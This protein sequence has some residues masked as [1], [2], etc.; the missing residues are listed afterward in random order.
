VSFADRGI[1]VCSNTQ[2]GVNFRFGSY[3]KVNV[4]L[5]SLSGKSVGEFTTSNGIVTLSKKDCQPGT[6]VVKWHSENIEG[7]QKVLLQGR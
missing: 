1:P 5:F 4:S 3:Q 2:Q 6:Y 7:V